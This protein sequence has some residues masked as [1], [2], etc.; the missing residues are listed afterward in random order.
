MLVIR[1]KYS[2]ALTRLTYDSRGYTFQLSNLHLTPESAEPMKYSYDR[3]GEQALERLDLISPPPRSALPRNSR[4]YSER[5]NGIPNTKE[6]MEAEIVKETNS[7]PKRDLYLLLR[8]NA[9]TDKVLGALWKEVNTVPEWVDWAQI[10]RGQEVFY[11]Y[12]GPALTGL[13]FQSLLGG[14][15]TTSPIFIPH[16]AR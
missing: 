9:S 15:V 8:D 7:D 13:A 11:R 16:Y 4:K 12:G 6:E 2:N 1:V 10:S 3:L 14:M 5:Q